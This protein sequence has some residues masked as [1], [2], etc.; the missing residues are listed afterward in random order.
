ME[1]AV[2]DPRHLD[3]DQLFL[4]PVKL[5]GQVTCTNGF[6][7]TLRAWR[8]IVALSRKASVDA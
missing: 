2:L 4:R 7:G 6:P 3:A 1:I 5:D 8:L